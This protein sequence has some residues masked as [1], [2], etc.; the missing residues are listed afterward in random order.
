MGR[1]IV[2]PAWRTAGVLAQIR[3]LLHLEERLGERRVGLVHRNHIRAER[4]RFAIGLECL[5]SAIHLYVAH[6]QDPQHIGQASLVVLVGGNDPRGGPFVPPIHGTL[7]DPVEVFQPKSS[8][9]GG[10]A[11]QSQRARV[12]VVH[13]VRKTPRA[14]GPG[15]RVV[16]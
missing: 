13:D 3:I 16:G 6:A 15:I 14:A 10:V 2:R 12:H 5:R 1:H 11:E 7:V 8:V 4:E 9:L